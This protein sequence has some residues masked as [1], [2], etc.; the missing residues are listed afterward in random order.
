M[1]TCKICNKEFK[2][3]TNSHLR[4][5]HSIDRDEYLRLFP[6]STMTDL[7]VLE[8]ISKATKGKSYVERYGKDKA[9][10]LI[11]RRREDALRQFED[12]N[13]RIVRR[14]HNWKGYGDISGD[15]WR[16][17][18]IAGKEKNLG[19]DLTLEF[20]WEL[21]EKQKGLCALSGLPIEFET[22]L[23]ALNKNGYQRRT[24]SLDRIDSSKGYLRSNVQWVHK[25]INQMKS[26]RTD[27]EFISL[28]N[29]VA[30]YQ[31]TK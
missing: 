31:G 4:D 18:K 7:S 22:R 15:Y 20:L 17:I 27:K 2:K 21:Y 19:F 8:S 3:I 1:I 11:K 9:N 28:C 13:Q 26:C 16:C 30:L 10:K 29:T 5:K 23:G 12:I 25:E 6:G 24:A 14:N